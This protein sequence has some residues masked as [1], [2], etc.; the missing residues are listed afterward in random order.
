MYVSS[1]I[2]SSQRKITP[3]TE[4]LPESFSHPGLCHIKQECQES[5]IQGKIH[6]QQN[7]NESLSFRELCDSKLPGLH[8]FDNMT[9]IY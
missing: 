1:R 3:Q 9:I 5:L 4:I 6:I 8:P 2:I 7:L